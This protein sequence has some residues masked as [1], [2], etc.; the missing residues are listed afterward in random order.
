MCLQVKSYRSPSSNMKKYLTRT[1]I[2]SIAFLKI[3]KRKKN[4]NSKLHN[5]SP[6]MALSQLRQFL[7]RASLLEEGSYL[8]AKE[9]NETK[10]SILKSTPRPQANT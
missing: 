1:A 3:S 10:L 7:H 2:S 9:P 5:F 6:N 8:L 4:H